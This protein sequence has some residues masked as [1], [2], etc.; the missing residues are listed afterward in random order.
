MS[1]ATK[2]IRPGAIGPG[3][4]RARSSKPHNWSGNWHLGM[5]RKSPG[6]SDFLARRPIE[7]PIRRPESPGG[8]GNSTR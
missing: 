3:L 6:P 5:L 4:Y 8:A 7:P 2:P 1:D